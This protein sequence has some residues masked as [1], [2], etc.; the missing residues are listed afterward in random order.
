MPEGDTI[1]RAAAALRI[2]LVGQPLVNVEARRLVGPL[3]EPGRVIETVDSHGK[4]LE[5]T[6]DDGLVLHTHMRMTG[7]WHLYRPGERWRKSSQQA[8]V[9]I[10]VPDWVAVCFN[11]PVV[12]TYR[13]ADRRRHPGMGAL[14]PDLCGDDP[15]LAE[16]L[17]RLS[18]YEDPA[19]PIHEVLLDQRIACGVGNVYKS[20]VLFA[21]STSPFAPLDMLSD[22][23]RWALLETSSLLLRAN[24]Q[25]AGRITTTSAP[26]GLAVYGRT[27]KPCLRCGTAVRAGRFGEHARTTYWCPV[28]Q[29]DVAR[30]DRERVEARHEP[31]PAAARHDPPPGTHGALRTRRSV[32]GSR[33]H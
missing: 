9:T 12:E 6:W 28:C 3:P 19:A 32:P 14:G 27:G 2:A 30:H 16:C 4:H 11:A 10:E 31:R 33:P 7:S 18:F 15:D 17:R 26:G 21:C 22:A 20:E 8:R 1:Y 13:Q 24:L 25:H 29:P 23:E 5:L